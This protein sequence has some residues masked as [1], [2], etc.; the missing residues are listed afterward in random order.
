MPRT[1]SRV[2]CVAFVLQNFLIPTPLKPT[3]PDDQIFLR[4]HDVALL[5]EDE[6][7]AEYDNETRE[8]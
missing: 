5:E 8:W 2:S 3:S 4:K 6:L 1:I 7:L